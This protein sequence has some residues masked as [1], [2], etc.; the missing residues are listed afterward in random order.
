M[1]SDEDKKKA[2]GLVEQAESLLSTF[3]N[4]PE[5]KTQRANKAFD[6][7]DEAI[8]LDPENDA[9]RGNRGGAKAHLGDHHGAMSDCDEAI[10]LNPKM[11][12]HG[13]T[14]VRQKLV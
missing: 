12:P 14:E 11:P 2:Q 3:P 9:A 10:R 1:A 8:A 6:L 7:L 5:H 13:I 4:E